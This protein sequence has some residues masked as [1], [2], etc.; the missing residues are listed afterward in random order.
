MS[1]FKK[2]LKKLFLTKDIIDFAEELSKHSPSGAKVVGRG[3]II[4]DP[5]LVAAS[6]EVKEMRESAKEIVNGQ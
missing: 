6:E 5:K 3:A 2:M 1:I 4:C